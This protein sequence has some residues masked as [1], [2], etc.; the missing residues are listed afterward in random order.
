MYSKIWIRK[1]SLTTHL[2][3]LISG[4]DLSIFEQN[5]SIFEMLQKAEL[6]DSNSKKQKVRR[7][8]I[9][10]WHVINRFH[11]TH[12]RREIKWIHFQF[13]LV[14]EIS[15]SICFAPTK[16]ITFT[17]ERNDPY[18]K[19]YYELSLVVLKLKHKYN[20]DIFHSQESSLL[21]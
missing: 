1:H 5:Y 9:T 12:M 21:T 8:L 7:Y 11:N 14:T 2:K 4:T 3:S 20:N 15:S 17:C 19:S 13:Y 10:T 6:C 16:V 18:I